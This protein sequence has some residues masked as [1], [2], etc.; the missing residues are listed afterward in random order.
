MAALHRCLSMPLALLGM[1]LLLAGCVMPRSPSGRLDNT[2]Q[3]NTAPDY[4]IRASVAGK[5]YVI[6]GASSSLGRG[7]AL[8]LA[9]MRANVVLAAPSVEVLADMAAKV[10]AAGG[11]PLAVVTDVARA[12]DIQRL[13]ALAVAKFGRIDVWINNAAVEA[14]GRFEDIA[15]EEHGRL[16]DVNLKGVVYGSHAALRQFRVQRAGTLV[17]ISPAGSEVPL[18]Y[19]ASYA[20]S[21]AGVRSLGQALDQEIRLTG[22]NSV[23]VATVAPSAGCRQDTAGSIPT[24]R[25]PSPADAQQA[26]DAIIRLSLHPQQNPAVGEAGGAS[27]ACH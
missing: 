2:R 19:Q 14:S 1:A 6:T 4:A 17:N 16:I 9:A 12:E 5:T 10:S 8:E 25:V 21:T 15:P 7:L 13:A 27:R 20:A 24:P 22:L 26:I 18:A 3:D 23:S 11:R